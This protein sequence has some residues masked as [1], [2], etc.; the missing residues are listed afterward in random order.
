MSSG[1]DVIEV[2]QMKV[3]GTEQEIKWI[4]EAQQNNCDGCPFSALCAGVAKKDSE[5]Y[6]K[7]KQTCQ[8]FLG[9]TIEF[10]I[11]NNI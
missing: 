4:K 11:E 6:G 8:E 9:T 2:S 7:V 1:Y 3:N 5:Q 10:V